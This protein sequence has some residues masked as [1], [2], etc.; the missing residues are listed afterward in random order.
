[1]E[2]MVTANNNKEKM[3]LKTGNGTSIC[4]WIESAS[5]T[6]SVLWNQNKGF[7]YELIVESIQ[8]DLHFEHFLIN[9]IRVGEKRTNI[10]NPIDQVHRYTF[11]Y[12]HFVQITHSTL[13]VNLNAQAGSLLVGYNISNVI[14]TA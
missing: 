14:F 1:M 6:D 5:N 12:V 3:P 2:V 4:N 13:T 10:L 7:S 8:I 9:G 11:M